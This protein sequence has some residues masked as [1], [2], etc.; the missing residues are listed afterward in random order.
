MYIA[1][2]YFDSKMV[3]KIGWICFMQK[4]TKKNIYIYFDFGVKCDQRS[5]I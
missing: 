5:L 2:I 3:L 1:V 4:K